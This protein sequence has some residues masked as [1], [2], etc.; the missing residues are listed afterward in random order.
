MLKNLNHGTRR[1]T[2]HASNASMSTNKTAKIGPSSQGHLPAE[3][4]AQARTSVRLSGGD[5]TQ[6]DLQVQ[7]ATLGAVEK[8]RATLGTTEKSNLLCNLVRTRFRSTFDHLGNIPPTPFLLRAGT[9]DQLPAK[10]DESSGSGHSL[11]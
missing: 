3:Q 2:Q 11:V 10:P 4:M 9:L 1:A 5:E 7:L 6:G 8:L